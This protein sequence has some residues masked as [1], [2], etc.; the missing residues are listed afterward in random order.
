[1]DYGLWLS[2]FFGK[3]VRTAVGLWIKIR[4]NQDWINPSSLENFCLVWL[5]SD[6]EHYPPELLALLPLKFSKKKHLTQCMCSIIIALDA[7]RG[8]FESLG[9]CNHAC[10]LLLISHKAIW[11]ERLVLEKAMTDWFI[12]NRSQDKFFGYNL[13]KIK[14]TKSIYLSKKNVMNNKDV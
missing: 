8:E 14:S 6:L 5:I 1:M 7:L 11:K 12:H 10:W 2:A 13:R 3:N 9:I 4:N